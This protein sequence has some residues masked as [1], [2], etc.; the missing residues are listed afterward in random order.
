MEEKHFDYWEFHKIYQEIEHDPFNV[1]IKIEN[2]LHNYPTDYNAYAY[3]IYAL[4]VTADFDNATKHLRIL[5][6]KYK[7]DANFLKYSNKVD[8][9]KTDILT[10]EVRLLCHRGEYDKI[11]KL[12][13]QNK[14]K[15][16]SLSN[17]FVLFYCLKQQ[18]RLDV[19]KREPNGYLFRQIVEYHEDDFLNHIKKHLAEYNK[20]L[21][22]PNKNIFVPDFP[23]EEVLQEVKKYIPSCKKTCPG[24]CDDVYY[25]KYE[26][27]G[28]EDNKLVDYFKVVCFQNTKDMITICPINYGQNMPC[29]DLSYIRE[30]HIKPQTKSNRIG[31]IEKFNKKYKRP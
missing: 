2:Y 7:N 1:K 31:Q 8:L 24:F 19:A 4:I 25:F 30:K 20:D 3:Y 11:Q 28:R 18:G 12:Y 14:E 29:V 26:E 23:I 5:K 13:M 27:C 16:S 6:E 22:Q 21:D 15:L 17:S 10:D 9:L